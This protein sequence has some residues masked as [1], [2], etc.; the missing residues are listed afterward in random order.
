MVEGLRTTMEF[1]NALDEP[2]AESRRWGVS[3][4]LVFDDRRRSG[5]S[6]GRIEGPTEYRDWLAASWGLTDERPHFTLVEVIAVRGQR[7][8]AIV[9]EV[10]YG[11]DM[12][13]RHIECWRLDADVRLAD[14]ARAFDLDDLDEA[15]AELDR[16]H[17]ETDETDAPS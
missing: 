13:L 2:P 8:A 11:H 12:S 5:F 10:D 6:F 15:I 3:D 17:T 14:R 1:L 4:D 7:C 9:I 16:L